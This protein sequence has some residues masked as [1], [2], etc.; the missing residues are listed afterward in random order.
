[1]KLG[2]R[3]IRVRS[4]VLEVRAY[5]IPKTGRAVSRVR[6]P[7]KPWST[8]SD[9]GRFQSFPDAQVAMVKQFGRPAR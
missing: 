9:E 2:Q 1:M 5:Y 8:L 6:Q 7:G 3:L 4:A